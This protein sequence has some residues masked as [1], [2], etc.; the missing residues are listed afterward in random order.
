[1]K[2]ILEQLKKLSDWIYIRNLTFFPLVAQL[3]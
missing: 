2:L 1:M 3:I